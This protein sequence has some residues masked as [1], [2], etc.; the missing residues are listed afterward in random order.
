MKLYSTR[1]AA[2]RLGVTARTIQQW[3]NDGK[4]PGA[5]KLDPTGQTSPYRI[6][7]ADIVAFEQQRLERRPAAA[8]DNGNGA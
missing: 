7:E 1:E 4:L 2:Q 3:I 8:N 5:Y 6:P